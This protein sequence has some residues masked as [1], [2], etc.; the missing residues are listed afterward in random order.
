MMSPLAMGLLLLVSL[1]GVIF[2][3]IRRFLP[4]FVMQ[5]LNSGKRWHLEALLERLQH[6]H[7][8]VLVCGGIR[9]EL[10][11]RGL[12]GTDI[13]FPFFHPQASWLARR[14]GH[15]LHVD[16]REFEGA[17]RLRGWLDESRNDVRMQ[18]LLAQAA[19]EW[20]ASGRDPGFLLREARL[21]QFAGWAAGSSVALT[22]DEQ[23]E[24][25]FVKSDFVLRQLTLRTIGCH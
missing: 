4:L 23:V 8:D 20:E 7:C 24:S 19:G 2:S 17:E 15:A 5:P 18:R 22:G 25:T 21:D 13:H 16:W 1:A 6:W 12:A 14:H 11:D 9:R 3:V 10:A